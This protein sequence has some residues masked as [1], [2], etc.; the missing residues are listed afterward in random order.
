M[1][2]NDLRFAP[3]IDRFCEANE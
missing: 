2:L 1:L 3:E